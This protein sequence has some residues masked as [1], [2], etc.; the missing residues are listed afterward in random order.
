MKLM[1]R[2][3]YWQPYQCASGWWSRRG[4][5]RW[6][7][8]EVGCSARARWYS[9]SCSGICTCAHT[10]F[11]SVTL[12]C[13]L[14]SAMFVRGGF[15]CGVVCFLARRCWEAAHGSCLSR[16]HARALQVPH[17]KADMPERFKKLL[18]RISRNCR[19][20]SLRGAQ[21][22]TRRRDAG[23]WQDPAHLVHG[24]SLLQGDD[25]VPQISVPGR[26]RSQG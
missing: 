20:F 13:S 14:A 26:A 9:S 12:G 7:T 3:P 18:V 19:H 1:K 6:T 24:Q 22:S 8:S 11:R 21:L 16:L 2:N 15:A 23:A 17:R 10:L 4:W 25:G 5:G